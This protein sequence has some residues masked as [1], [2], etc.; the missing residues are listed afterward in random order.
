MTS[1]LPGFSEHHFTPKPGL[2]VDPFAEWRTGN[3]LRDIE[4]G[5]V[6]YLGPQLPE[7][8]IKMPEGASVRCALLS[9]SAA[10]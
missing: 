9:L 10:T 5:A 8:D 3:C 7:F 1:L 4:G 6:F 2:V